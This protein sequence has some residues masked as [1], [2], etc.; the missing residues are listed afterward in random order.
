MNSRRTTTK[1]F[2]LVLVATVVVVAGILSGTRGVRAQTAVPFPSDLPWFN[3][4]RPLTLGDLK[5]RAVLL[6]FFTP[7]CINCVHMLP[8]EQRLEEHF[9]DRL[10]VIGIDSPKFTASS[11]RAG[12]ES[13]IERYELRH[14]IVLD[15]KS[16]LWN[17]YGVQAWPTLVLIGPDGRVRAR[18]I[19]EQSYEQLAAPVEAALADAPPASSLKPL[20][21]RAMRMPKGALATPGGIAVS[22]TQVA[23]ADSGHNRIV[24]TDRNGKLQAVIGTGCAGRA[25][26]DY[27]HAEFDRPQGLTFHDGALYVAD[28]DNQLLR[29]I[30]LAT[31]EVGTIAGNGERGYRNNGESAAL[32]ATLNSPWDLAWS[33][34]KLYVSMAG[35]HQI[36]RYDAAAKTIGPWA[37]TGAEGLQDGARDEAEF[38]QPSGLSAHGGTLYDVDPESSSVRAITLP[39]GEVKTL[40]GR[41]LFDFGMKNGSTGR[42]LLQHAEGIVWNAGS[43]YIADTF[44]DALRSLDLGSHEVRTVAT[45]LKRPLAVAALSP[46]TLLVA[47]GNANR[48][49]MVH[50]PDG[51]VTPWP[52]TGLKAPDA[53]SCATR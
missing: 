53:G 11:T 52:V 7:G 51:K 16:S 34:D 46:D 5:G 32:A 39:D 6:D 50:L 2:L 9:G 24:L 10:V 23:I 1:R 19:G 36:W 4:G 45:S 26:G 47:E 15:P 43:L 17:A 44:N 40:V 31:H 37:G 35:N 48:I 14:P 20:P 13:F 30:D 25:D 22:A 8:A 33:G 42:A 49:V 27:A 21:L 28:T 18:L 3:V 29:R 41:G 12:L 38:A